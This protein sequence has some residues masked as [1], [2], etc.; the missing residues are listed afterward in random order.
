MFCSR[1]ICAMRILDVEGTSKEEIVLN[2]KEILLE[3]I[4]EPNFTLPY[5]RDLSTLEIMVKGRTAEGQESSSHRDVRMCCDPPHL[6][7]MSGNAPFWIRY[8]RRP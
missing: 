2:P 1:T 4:D 5:P 6:V 7:S 8:S 3:C